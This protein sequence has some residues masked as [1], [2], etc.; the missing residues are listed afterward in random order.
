M[1]DE[2]RS[3]GTDNNTET[4]SFHM[5]VNSLL[6]QDNYYTPT[7]LT[8]LKIRCSQCSQCRV[9]VIGNEPFTCTNS[10]IHSFRVLYGV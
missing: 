5:T 8:V 4:E 2:L 1:F 3:L 9:K 10:P 7:K 6:Y